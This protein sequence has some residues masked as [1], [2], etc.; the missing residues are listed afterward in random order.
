MNYY[1]ENDPRAAEWLRQLIAAGQIPAGVVDERSICEVQPADVAEFVQCH[2]FAGIGGWPYALRL[3][4]WPEDRPVWTG[5]CPCQP[6]SVAGRGLGIKDARHLWPVFRRLI[7][8][9]RPSIVFG[10]QVAAAAGREWL[11]RVRVNLARLG[12]AVGGADLCASGIGAPHIRQRL[13]WV[14]H[15]EHAKRRAEQQINSESHGRN[16][17]GG[18][19]DARGLADANEGQCGWLT[20]WQ[21]CERDGQKAGRLEGNSQPQSGCS[22]VGLADPNGSQSWDGGLQPSGRQL[23]QPENEATRGMVQSNST[24]RESG[25]TATEAARHGHTAEPA[26]GDGGLGGAHDARSQGRHGP[27]LPER[28]HEQAARAGSSPWDSYE[29]LPCLD[30]KSRRVE[31]GTFPLAHGIPGRVGLLR[32]YGNAIVAPLAAEF[33]KASVEALE[34][35]CGTNER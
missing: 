2:F 20:D 10:E 8:R 24:G 32:G 35:T 34:M 3:A 31:S 23:Q 25:R 14:A 18:G 33:I 1:N 22:V 7:G 12:Y 29:L 15:T 16:R 17:S 19:G 5:S 26:G 6:F 21:G 27:K 13:Y 30:G 9:C 28:A 4:G 11:T